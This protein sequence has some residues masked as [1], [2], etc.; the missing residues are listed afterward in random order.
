LVGKT[1]VFD[2][3]IISE[4]IERDMLKA[5]SSLFDLTYENKGGVL[6]YLVSGI[7]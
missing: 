6:D 7:Y 2:F 4:L 3:P 5:P 1:G